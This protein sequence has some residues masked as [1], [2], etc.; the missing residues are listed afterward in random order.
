MPIKERADQPSS[1]LGYKNPDEK[2]EREGF[3]FLDDVPPEETFRVAQEHLEDI[4]GYVRNSDGS[5]RPIKDK[6]GDVLLE[7]YGKE[8]CLSVLARTEYIAAELKKALGDTEILNE[9]SDV[10]V[11]DVTVEKVRQ[12][13]LNL[14]PLA[15][16]IP[17]EVLANYGESSQAIR[18]YQNQQVEGYGYPAGTNMYLYP[19]WDEMFAYKK[20]PGDA[21]DEVRYY[22]RDTD[23]QAFD[24]DGHTPQEINF[25]HRLSTHVLLAPLFAEE[26]TTHM[27]RVIDQANQTGQVLPEKAFGYLR[28]EDGTYRN[29]DVNR[30]KVRMLLHDIGRWATHHQD[31][32]ESMP[33]LIAHSLGI[34]P[35]LIQFEFNHEYRY[36]S[37]DDSLVNPQNI[38]IEETIFHFIDFI[39]KRSNENDLES[40]EIRSL[41]QLVEHAISRAAGYNG[42]LKLY[43]DS[44]QGRTVSV[45]EKEW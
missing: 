10:A 33:D 29:I 17:D 22:Y 18:A 37:K 16:G 11:S 8:A 43:L 35:P 3:E 44:I 28:Q 32:H 31:L 14:S 2:T 45:E 1:D 20:Q 25:Y 21:S 26:L 41:D 23:P 7:K 15:K 9:G 39:A 36:F 19:K 30:M 38:P 40:D 4:F 13:I 12:V 6:N 34:E 27:N 24:A 42:A 5:K